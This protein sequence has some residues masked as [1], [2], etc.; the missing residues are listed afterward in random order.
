MV[1]RFYV[2]R[3][4]KD[5]DSRMSISVICIQMSLLRSNHVLKV[6]THLTDEINLTKSSCHDDV[7]IALWSI[8]VET[9][10]INIY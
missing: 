9:L 8:G 5:H 7:K 2:T 6:Q 4:L 1:S 3:Q 10:F